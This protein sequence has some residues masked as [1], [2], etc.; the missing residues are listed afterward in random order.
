[1]KEIEDNKTNGNIL[2]AHRLEEL[3]S[4]KWLYHPKQSTDSVQSPSKY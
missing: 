4:L 3:I 1:M 2:S